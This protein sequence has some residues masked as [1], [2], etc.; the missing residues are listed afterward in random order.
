[1][2][3][4]IE[5]KNIDKDQIDWNEHAKYWDEFDDGKLYTKHTFSLLSDRIDIK[6]LNILDFGCG[7]GLLIDYLTKEAKAIVAIDTAEKMIEVLNNKNYNNVSTLNVELS[8]KTINSNPV[9][10]QQFDLIVS[11]SVCAFLLNYQEVLALIK[12]LLKPNGIFVQWDWLRT[13]KD[14]G[15]GFSEEM[16]RDNYKAVGLQTESVSIPFH[17]MENNEKMEVIMAIGT[18]YR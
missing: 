9:L 10:N 1:M 6:D 11:S 12:S 17:L 18:L 15:F 5:R 14:P 16:I 3:E 7:T 8:Q 2:S 4:E 13:E